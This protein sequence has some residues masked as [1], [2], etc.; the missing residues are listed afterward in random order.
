M[1]ATSFRQGGKDVFSIKSGD[2]GELN[3]LE[4][5]IEA[6]GACKQVRMAQVGICECFCECVCLPLCY[7]PRHVHTLT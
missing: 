2:V 5:R 6:T 4:V 3:R 7:A 1:P